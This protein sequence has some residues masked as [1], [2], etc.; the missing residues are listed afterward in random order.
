MTSARAS[1]QSPQAEDRSALDCPLQPRDAIFILVKDA[2]DRFSPDGLSRLQAKS[3]G[4][5]LDYID[6]HLHI[7]PQRCIDMH[8]AASASGVLAMEARIAE[9]AGTQ[10]AIEGCVGRL[11]H[12]V[13]HR[14]HSLPKATME[15]FRPV[16]FGSPN[17]TTIPL[18]CR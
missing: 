7:M 17:V 2:V 13:D 6:R 1:P 18:A 15:Q 8:I 9:T 16:Y 3:A 5:A 4:V 11:L 14:L 10:D 12:G